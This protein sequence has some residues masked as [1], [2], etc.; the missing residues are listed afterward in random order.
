MRELDPLAF[1]ERERRLAAVARE[2]DPV[3]LRALVSELADG[4]GYGRALGLR[5]AVIGGDGGY[6][7]QCLTSADTGLRRRA[8]VAAVRM[9]V[10]AEAVVEL[11]DELPAALR[12]AL[13]QAVR[14]H[15]R[16]ELAE[17]LLA[18]VRGRFGDAEAAAVLPGCS[19][20]TVAAVLPELSHAVGSWR[21]LARRHTGVLLDHLE[22]ELGRTP[23][24]HWSAL[25]ARVG[26]AVLVEA[27]AT[28]P[29]RV[30][31]LLERTAGEV[32]IP[33]RLRR[34]IGGLARHDPARLL[35]LLV[36]PRRVGPVPGGRRLWRA[37][38]GAGDEDLVALARV[39]GGRQLV[40]F[41]HW[42]P[43][44][45]RA[46]VYAGA[47]GERDLVAYGVP[48]GALDELPWW[49]RDAEARRLLALRV[50]ADDPD[51]RLAVTARTRWESAA[52]VLAEAIRRPLAEERARAYRLDIAAAAATRDPE[53]FGGH[54]ATLTR[55]RNEQDPVR[56]AALEALAAVPPWLFRT[57]DVPVLA[58]LITDA[59][60]ARDCSWQT[61]S[62]V[63]RLATRLIREGAA[64]R[65]PA[66]ADRGLDALG[67]FGGQ[68]SVPGL[69]GLDRELPRGAEHE[70]FAALRPRIE[71]DAR[72]GFFGVALALA[73]GLGRRAWR[74]PELQEY[75]DRARRA[76]ND[77]TVREAVRLWL[78]PPASRAERV[79]RVLRDDRSTITIDAVRD[80]VGWLR[81]DLLDQVLTADAR[82]RF[83]ARGVRYVPMFRRCFHAWLPRQCARYRELLAEL[84]GDEQVP[85]HERVRAIGSMRALPGSTATLRRLAGAKEV[86]DAEAALAAL[87]W[88]EEPS[89]VLAEL[90]ALA[91]TDRARV[92][93]YAA[94]RCARFVAPGP[95]GGI[96]APV[97]SAPKVT[98][99][100]EAVRL[101]AELRVPGAPAL[102]GRVY[103]APGQHRDVRRAV[104]S[105]CRLLLDE[106]AAWEV[107]TDA[108]TAE[109][110]IS[111]ALLETAPDGVPE[112]HRG[113]Y[114]ELVR[115]VAASAD[116]DTARR[117][118]GVLPSWSRWDAAGPGFLVPLVTD[119]A[120]TAT[121]RHALTALTTVAATTG[122]PAP[123]LAA[124]SGLL[125][126]GDADGHGPDR[127]RD[128]PARQRLQ[129][130]AGEVA[131][132]AA[133]DTGRPLA[134]ALS[135]LLADEPHRATAVELALA[136]VPWE[137]ADPAPLLAAHELAASAVLRARATGAL[138]SGLG[139]VVSRLPSD[140]LLAMARGLAE[141]APIFA[142]AVVGVAGA[143]AGWQRPWRDLLDR[144]R[145]HPDPDVRRDALDTFTGRE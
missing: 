46:A 118:L 48:L 81:T 9:G 3:G 80:A 88:T 15:G 44:S 21:A 12:R 39:L 82:G 145:D 11:V 109:P 115:A 27:A 119:L 86:A 43:P 144:L 6:V 130:L 65:R 106:P 142:V 92:A 7:E 98:A 114:T 108:S 137:A 50:V 49:A 139:S 128:L 127:D 110:A 41:L 104:I 99:R 94:T 76:P 55:L 138:R 71:A 54:L 69:A 1:P 75:V 103:R 74:M 20:R 124:A 40:A 107:L 112:R 84:A 66:L 17:S 38:A 58:G 63:N 90:L 105:A 89:D 83:L 25:W 131:A 100:K 85:Q 79:E 56:A 101:C 123:V 31:G 72:R 2:L 18:R 22:D 8:L 59:S 97:L 37:L 141:D 121:W 4:G 91:D 10:A 67:R 126:G 102:V 136:A 60:Q 143:E 36:D 35:R 132:A 87:A 34:T 57:G 140:R 113:R 134:T 13:Y 117:G 68:V 64:T 95:L 61:R 47:V 53:L 16:T 62:A 133:H 19:G 70:V 77:S 28:E 111:T 116:P 32:A 24:V 45:R 30:F 120:S 42:L 51:V 23:R 5:L 33:A 125:A 93:V 29:E 78:A 26:G 52:P 73:A 129:A 96:L 135:A 14:A 122:D